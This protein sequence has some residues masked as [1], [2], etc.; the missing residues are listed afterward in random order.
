MMSYFGLILA[1]ATKYDRNL[2][3]GTII[4]TMLPYSI[5]FTI[6]WMTLFFIWV[7]GFGLPV[8]PGAPTYYVP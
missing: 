3:I 7:F 6:G 5:L 1:F 8:G 2:G 4:S